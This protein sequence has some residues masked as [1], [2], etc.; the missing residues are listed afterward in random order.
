[1]VSTPRRL[2]LLLPAA[3]LALAGAALLPAAGCRFL[4]ER[5]PRLRDDLGYAGPEI[6]LGEASGNHRL[7]LTAPSGGWTFK[8]DTVEEAYGHRRVLVTARRPN[9]AF[10][11]TQALAEH[12]IRVPVPTGVPIRVYAR[13]L[14]HDA[15]GKGAG[16]TFVPTAS[17]FDPA[18]E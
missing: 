10:M 18:G 16:W 9:P 14:D 8:L 5:E 7:T 6:A 11:H 3:T 15:S 4:P 13:V 2:R 1:M 17:S 12:N